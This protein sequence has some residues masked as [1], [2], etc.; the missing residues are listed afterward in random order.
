MA[1]PRE[2]K[3]STSFPAAQT[4]IEVKKCIKVIYYEFRATGQK[5]SAKYIKLT[6][7]RYK[8]A[9]MVMLIGLKCSITHA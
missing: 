9:E 2:V 1:M 3:F 4:R 7:S 8:H 6:K 5:K